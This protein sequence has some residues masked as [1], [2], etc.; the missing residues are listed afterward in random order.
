MYRKQ[1]T[2]Y[3]KTLST[4]SHHGAK[5]PANSCDVVYI[6]D[7]HVR[8]WVSPVSLMSYLDLDLFDTLP[9]MSYVGVLPITFPLGFVIYVLGVYKRSCMYWCCIEITVCVM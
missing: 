6:Q 8:D 3:C 4:H 9:V 7:I 1:C 2:D 5:S